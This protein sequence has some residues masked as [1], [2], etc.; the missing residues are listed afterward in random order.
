M[1]ASYR[2]DE[3]PSLPQEL[4]GCEVLKLARLNPD[5]I[6]ELCKSMLGQ[7]GYTAELVS[8]LEAETEGNLSITQLA[9]SLECCNGGWRGVG[10]GGWAQA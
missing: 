5:G 7:N 9:P 2:D 3:C 8:F 4:P 6:T 10:S 1:V